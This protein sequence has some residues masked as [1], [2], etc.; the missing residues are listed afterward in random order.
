M[1]NFWGKHSRLPEVLNETEAAELVEMVNE[2]QKNKIDEEGF[3]FKVEEIDE[4]LVKNVSKYADTQISPCCSFW[5][6]IITQ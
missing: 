3:E 1:Y 2:W 5:G 4:K 6:G